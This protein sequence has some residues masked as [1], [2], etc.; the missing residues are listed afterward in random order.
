MA[1]RVWSKAGFSYQ[2]LKLK[3][4]KQLCRLSFDCSEEITSKQFNFLTQNLKSKYLSYLSRAYY[5]YAL[6]L[7]LLIDLWHP[8]IWFY[9]FKNQIQNELFIFM[10]RHFQ[11]NISN[12]NNFQLTIFFI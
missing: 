11:V 7:L 9:S 4:I 1:L 2:R 5:Y 12:Q 6:L 3:I 8:C 10:Q